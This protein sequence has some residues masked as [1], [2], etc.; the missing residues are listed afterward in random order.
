VPAD[1]HRAR[2][3]TLA[4]VRHGD[5]L[6]LIRHPESGKRFAGQWNGVGGHV[7]PGEGVRAAAR[8]ELHE[9]AGVDAPGLRL[10][11]VIHESG[12]QGEAWL[13]FVFAGE[14]ASRALRPA[15]GH[16]VAWHPLSALPSPLV[17]DVEEL[18]PHV[19]AEGDPVF[20]TET[21]DGGDAR[22]SLELDEGPRGEAGRPR[23]RGEH[24]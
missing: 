19:L 5:A 24:R 8:R 6:L 7:E 18:L 11:A 20:L 23:A 10:R 17:H 13:V 2:L 22:L 14:A 12:L 16:E 15:P 3:V 21:Y 4:F 9:E 1:P